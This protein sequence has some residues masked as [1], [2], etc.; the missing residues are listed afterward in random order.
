MH[1]TQIKAQETLSVSWAVSM[2]L[3]GLETRWSWGQRYVFFLSNGILP[4]RDDVEMGPNDIRCVIW[5]INKFFLFLFID[6]YFLK[7]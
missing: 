3:Q 4:E 1:T 6:H 7:M 2:F 5:T